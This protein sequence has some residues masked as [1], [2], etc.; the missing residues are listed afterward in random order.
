MQHLVFI[1]DDH[2]RE[3]SCFFFQFGKPMGVSMILIGT[4]HFEG[5][6]FLQNFRAVSRSIL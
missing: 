5:F 6:E 1:D 2:F 3:L 4:P